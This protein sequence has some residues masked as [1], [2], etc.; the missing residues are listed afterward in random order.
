MEKL[1]VKNVMFAQ[2]LG[3]I[4]DMDV[5]P[6]GNLYVISKYHDTPT[7]F[8]ISSANNTK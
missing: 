1:D 6:D 3:Q 5:S 7:I 4:T 8:W 2:G